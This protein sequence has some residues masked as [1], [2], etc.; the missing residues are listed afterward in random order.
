MGDSGWILCW[1]HG[2]SH[3]AESRE[4]ETNMLWHTLLVARL[5]GPLSLLGL[6]L[7]SPVC[8]PCEVS[9]VPGMS[10]VQIQGDQHTMAMGVCASSMVLRTI[11]THGRHPSGKESMWLLWEAPH[12]CLARSLLGH[13]Q[14]A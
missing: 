7:A 9:W 6:G 4:P 1:L 12:G 14:C 13:Q 10:L 2:P 5:L 8:V 11:N 3:L